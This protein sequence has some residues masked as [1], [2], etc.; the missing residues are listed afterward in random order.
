MDKDDITRRIIK[1]LE[2]SE[3]KGIDNLIEYLFESNFFEAP[4]STQFH[5]AQ[6][7]GLAEHSLNVYKT[8][9]SYYAAQHEFGIGGDS[10]ILVSLLHDLG[11]TGQFKKPNYIPN[12]ISDKKGGFIQS[13]KKPYETNKDLLA[14]PHEIRSIQIAS[15]FIELTEDESFAILQHNGMYG[16]LKYQLNGKEIPLQMLLHFSDLWCSRVVEIW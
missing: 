7:G 4:C 16:D 14:V 13:D 8:M 15:Q 6:P 12:M 3:R 10:I 1:L 5:L 11:K 2:S 9:V